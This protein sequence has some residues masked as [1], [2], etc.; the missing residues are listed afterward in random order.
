[1]ARKNSEQDYIHDMPVDRLLLESLRI[2]ENNIRE[3]FLRSPGDIA[4]WNARY[5]DAIREE[6]RAEQERKELEALL[7]EEHRERLALDGKK[8]TEKLLEIAVIRDERMQEARHTESDAVANKIRVRGWALAV[9]AKKDLLMSLGAT[10][11]EEM[12]DPFNKD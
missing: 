5:A 1:M 11:R 3:E 9:A 4:Y 6:L 12:R 10:L 8:T 2:D 7:T